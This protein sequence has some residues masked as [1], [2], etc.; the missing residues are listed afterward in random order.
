MNFGEK[1]KEIRKERGL[2]QKDLAQSLGVTQRTISYYEGSNMPPSNAE[3]VSKLAEVLN[4]RLD[5]LVES[6]GNTKIHKLIEKLKSDTDKH[7]IHWEKFNIARE[8]LGPQAGLAE[9]PRLYMS[10]FNQENFPQYANAQL[11]PA[12]SY[13]YAYSSGG[14]LVA[15][16]SKDNSVEFALFIVVDYETF[17][18]LTNNI[19]I[20]SLEDLYWSI[21]NSTSSVNNLIDEYLNRDFLKERN[22]EQLN[23]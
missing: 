23:F 1:L 20:E 13:F 10:I 5:D 18:F 9:T 11:D 12:N 16:F 14:Y 8:D 3:T 19:S 15:K 21:I 17:V 22:D 2:S 7:L 4:V 6:S